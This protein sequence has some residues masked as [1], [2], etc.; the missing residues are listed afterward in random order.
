[1]NKNNDYCW[2]WQIRSVA[3]WPKAIGHW[4]QKIDPISLKKTP[5]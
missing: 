2:Q 4:A 5:R 1:M 3:M